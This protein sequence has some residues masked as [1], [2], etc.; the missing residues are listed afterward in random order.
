MFG[1]FFLF[2]SVLACCNAVSAKDLRP[3]PEISTQPSLRVSSRL[4]TA[5]SEKDMVVTAHPE[6]TK[7]ARQILDRGGNAADALV[8]AQLVLGLVEPQSSGLG[9]GAFLLYHNALTGK[10]HSFDGR[11]TAP[12]SASPEM[13]WREDGSLM[14]FYEIAHSG[15]SVGVP[16]V[17]KL[18][19][20]VHDRFGQQEWGGLFDY[21]I[22]LAR[23]GFSVTPR[24]AAMVE[25]ERKRFSPFP[26]TQI[27][28]Q[29]VFVDRILENAAYANT[30]E[31]YRDQGSDF[32][33]HGAFAQE[34]VSV[35]KQHGGAL[36]VEDFAKYEVKE[37]PTLCDTY[38][39]KRV[40]SMNE[41]SSGGLTILMILKMLERFD[42]SEGP[43]SEN[44]HRIIEASRLAFAD[45]GQYMAD[46]DFVMTPNSMLLNDDYIQERSALIGR[47]AFDE[48]S[49]GVVVGFDERAV[50]P[51]GTFE[52]VGT[53]HISII[54]QWGNI[55][56]MTTTIESAFGSHI[57]VGGF[58][59]NNELTDFTFTKKDAPHVVANAIQ[60]GKRPRSSMAPTIVFNAE[61]TPL[62]VVGSAGGSRIISYVL[63][64]IIGIV[65]WDQ[66]LEGSMLTPH[67]LSRGGPVDV[68]LG[69]QY[70]LQALIDLGHE[71]V[72]RDLNSGVTAIHIDN[73]VYVGVADPRRE[74][75]AEGF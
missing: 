69:S 15:L 56:S 55:A 13:F 72:E 65:D 70:P 18:L 23:N 21:A 41:P 67:F 71:V 43:T 40:C 37:R 5:V 31:A 36:R 49:Y 20:V 35:V 4:S 22:S 66:S 75:V 60:G 24:L 30:L 62:L 61:N 28:F 11:E 45:R 39:K 64:R 27:Y 33:Y 12:M 63:Q 29:G 47:T 52:E 14:A 68:E 53:S 42:L 9:G 16:G 3:Q 58:L 10:T 44:L 34:I 26:V 73:G 8:A 57:M 74:G 50:A 25:N 7:A 46:N 19:D 48:V 1:R 59:L 54:D 2:F 38:R 6:A 32:F 17:P 51:Q